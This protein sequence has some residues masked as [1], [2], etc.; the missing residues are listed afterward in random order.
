MELYRR[1]GMSSKI[2]KE[3]FA[4]LI[5]NSVPLACLLAMV[6]RAMRTVRSTAQA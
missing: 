4:F 1:I 6:L 2:V 3:F 5:V